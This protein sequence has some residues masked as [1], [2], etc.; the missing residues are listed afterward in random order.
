MATIFTRRV[1]A[2]LLDFLVVSAFM[3]I[4]S[5]FLYGLLG[6][7]NVYQAYQVIPF[8]M[9]VLGLLYFILC[10]K[11][12]SASIGK[13]IMKLKVKSRNGVNISWL[14]AIVRNLSKIYWIPIIFDWLIGR[15]LKTDRIL[16]NITRTTVVNVFK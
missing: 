3:W 16:N 14:Q 6:P 13:A 1:I 7:K 8:L 11:I 12:A 2:Y 5:F 15:F 9:P 4:I 10:E